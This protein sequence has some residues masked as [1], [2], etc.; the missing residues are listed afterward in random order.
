MSQAKKEILCRVAGWDTG[1][2]DSWEEC[3][4]QTNGFPG[5]RFKSFN[6][7]EAAVNAYRGD[8][9]EYIGVIRKI[10]THPASPVNYDAIPEIRKDAIAVD[11]ACAKNPG[12]WNTDASEWQPAKNYSTCSHWPMAP[13]TSAST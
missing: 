5:A 8:P 10:F 1:V 9:S 7:Q 13:T 11:G 3:Q 6:T 4:Q 2:F 12:Q